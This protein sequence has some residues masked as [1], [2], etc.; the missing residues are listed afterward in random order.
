MTVV[1]RTHN[2]I[3]AAGLAEFGEGYVLD[4][5][6][7]DP[8][9]ELILLRSYRGYLEMPTDVPASVIAVGR[10]GVG[11]DNVPVDVMTAR[12]IPVFYA[13]G[14]NA[15]AVV[16]LTLG[17]MIIGARRLDK[18]FIWR[19]GFRG[20]DVAAAAE[21]AKGQFAGFELR[22]RRLG[23]VGLGNIGRRVAI[24][25]RALGMDVIGYDPNLS[26]ET[27][28]F[29][30]YVGVRIAETLNDVLVE[31]DVVTLHVPGG[32]ST[33]GLIGEGELTSMK[34][35]AMLVNAARAEVVD[36]EALQVAL[37]S[38]HLGHYATDLPTNELV[39]REEDVTMTPHLGAGTE[40]AEETCAVMVARQL[41]EFAEHGNVV[42]A[43]N[44]PDLVLPRTS[45]YRLTVMHNN[46][47]SMLATITAMVGE[48]GLNI[49]AQANRS[50]GLLAYTVLDCDQPFPDELI[51]RLADHDSIN[52]VRPL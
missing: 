9:P 27:H 3:A 33:N 41:R 34:P 25:A 24:A 31:S 35:G 7:V 28:E 32:A 16:E 12:G 2:N 22:G 29:L 52:R 5:E 42:N 43:V 45:A 11:V 1:V 6:G 14:G 4:P 47:V 39:Y 37:N 23:V 10:A 38:G 36:Q 26:N 48:Y 19:D 13:P 21:K 18:A 15:N 20:D 44:L 8:S 49:T 30:S 40:E 17:L 50:S 51:K 46:V